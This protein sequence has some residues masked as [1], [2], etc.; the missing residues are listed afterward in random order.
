MYP[1][2]PTRFCYFFRKDQYGKRYD[3][4]A[5]CAVTHVQDD[6]AEPSIKVAF[7]FLSPGDNFCKKDAHK[8]CMERLDLGHYFTTPFTG[9]SRK[10]VATLWNHLQKIGAFKS[11]LY[12]NK[13]F[14]TFCKNWRLKAF[15]KG[16][17]IYD[18]FAYEEPKTFSH[19]NLGKPRKSVKV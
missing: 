4:G 2:K 10:D 16:D 14:P 7:A 18:D 5:I 17:V 15:G 13:R 6:T 19:L 3:A 9:T 11:H 8:Y 12:Y 1:K